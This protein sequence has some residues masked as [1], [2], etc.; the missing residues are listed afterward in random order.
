MLAWP[1]AAGGGGGS[2]GFALGLRRLGWG[3]DEEFASRR[4]GAPN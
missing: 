3:D 1:E 4:R 2:V